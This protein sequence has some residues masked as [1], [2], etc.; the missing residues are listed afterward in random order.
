MTVSDS[1]V[2]DADPTTLYDRISDVTQMGSWS[3]ENRGAKI[4]QPRAAAY[5]GMVFEGH[6]K[7][8]A[9][10]WSTRCTVTA[11]D[12]GARFAFRVHVI[13]V[14]KPLLHGRIANWEYRFEPEAGGTRV[15]ET[16]NDDRTNWPDR[17]AGVFDRI[18][19][20]GKTFAD[21]QQK[22][23]HLTLRNLK[24]VIETDAT[25]S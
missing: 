19:T 21:F 20:R 9:F 11:A 6:N 12:P 5:V 2:I 15:T 8:G 23:I 10:R 17:V 24:R 13:G 3:P 22:N 14:G 18:V 25:T 4:A 16:W 1:I 7:R